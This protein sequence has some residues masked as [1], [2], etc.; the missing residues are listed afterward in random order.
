M[1]HLIVCVCKYVKKNIK[2]CVKQKKTKR[3]VKY[4]G[5]TPINVGTEIAVNKNVIKA[6]EKKEKEKISNIYNKTY[7]SMSLMSFEH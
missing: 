7:R 3:K 5:K 6:I 2:N 1:N 4:F